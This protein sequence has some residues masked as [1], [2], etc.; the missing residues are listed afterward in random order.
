M[1]SRESKLLVTFSS[2]EC[3]SIIIP[4]SCAVK[5]SRLKKSALAESPFLKTFQPLFGFLPGDVYS[6]VLLNCRG[7]GEKW[8]DQF[9]I[10]SIDSLE[11]SGLNIDRN[12]RLDLMGVRLF[13]DLPKVRTLT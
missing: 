8:V 10:L 9:S 5:Q 2:F 3:L 6:K 4:G 13:R 7:T 12:L 1:I 11:D